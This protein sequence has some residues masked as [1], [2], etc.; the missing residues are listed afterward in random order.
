MASNLLI[1]TSKCFNSFALAFWRT[2]L[3]RSRTE[4][5]LR[6]YAAG[7]RLG[8]G[9]F[10]IGTSGMETGS[11][12]VDLMADD[13]SEAVELRVLRADRAS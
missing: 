8:S 12:P 10:E 1:S 3:D 6:R 11:V 5:M 9:G 7:S 13:L 4:W 2:I